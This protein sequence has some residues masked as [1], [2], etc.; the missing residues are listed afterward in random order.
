M[1]VVCAIAVDEN[2]GNFEPNKIQI[3]RHLAAACLVDKRT[4]QDARSITHAEE[5][6]C[7]KHRTACIHDFVYEQHSPT[8]EIQFK[9]ADQAHLARTLTPISIT[10]EPYELDVWMAANAVQRA[11]ENNLA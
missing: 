11:N 3:D 1:C 7:V 9:L 2:V 6:A 10:A 4:G 8:G 5:V